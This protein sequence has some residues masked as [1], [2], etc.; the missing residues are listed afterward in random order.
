MAIENGQQPEYALADDMKALKSKV[1]DLDEHLDEFEAR[2]RRMEAMLAEMRASREAHWAKMAKVRAE[3]V[4]IRTKVANL[5]VR[6][7]YN[8]E[9]LEDV[10]Q[11]TGDLEKRL[12]RL[13][14][15]LAFLRRPQ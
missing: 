7:S 11:G 4:V 8:E 15:I 10:G 1:D 9:L 13:E 5:V 6:V 3:T 14:E 2:A 12:R